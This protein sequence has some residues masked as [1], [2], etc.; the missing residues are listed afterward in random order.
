VI[1]WLPKSESDLDS[2]E[3]FSIPDFL[4]KIRELHTLYG[5]RQGFEALQMVCTVLTEV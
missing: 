5:N 1:S 4:S 2:P 3:I